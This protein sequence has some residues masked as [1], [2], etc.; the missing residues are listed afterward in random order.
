MLDEIEMKSNIINC[1]CEFLEKANKIEDSFVDEK[2]NK[3]I[4]QTHKGN[5]IRI[6]FEMRKKIF[7][8][9]EEFYMPSA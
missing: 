2:N 7:E 8:I 4:N 3:F 9:F 6:C 5:Y 1:L